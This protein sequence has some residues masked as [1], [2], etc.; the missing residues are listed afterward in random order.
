[1]Q[2]GRQEA[3]SGYSSSGAVPTHGDFSTTN[4]DALSPRPSPDPSGATTIVVTKPGE[5][6]GKGLPPSG[7]R[8][9]D[10][11]ARAKRRSDRLP[12]FSITTG[13]RTRNFLASLATRETIS[14]L[15]CVLGLTG[16]LMVYGLLQER[17]M[18]IPFGK[19]QARF[20]H[21]LFLVLCNRIVACFVALVA[22]LVTRG[23]VEPVA[24]LTSY[25]AVSV[26][27]VI[28]S[29][30]QYEALKYVSFP[31]QVLAKCVKMIPVML[32]QTII[33]REVYSVKE[34]VYA[35]VIVGGCATFLLEGNVASSVGLSKTSAVE[36]LYI[37][38]GALLLVYLA[39]DGFTSTWQDRLFS[40]YDMD[41]WN[42]VLY[43]T[44]CSIVL[45]TTGLLGTGKLWPAV[46]FMR[47]NPEAWTWVLAISLAS[48]TV[49]FFV[50]HTIKSYGAL[51]FATIMTT[52]QW[53]SI[54]LS[55]LVFGHPL[56][57]GQ[58]MGTVLVFGALYHKFYHKSRS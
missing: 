54:L 37:Y 9:S 23:S 11:S 14:A 45:S 34:Y 57:R 31:V 6:G 3:W 16:S 30:C 38:G 44:A 50:S 58:W 42:Q 21:S 18:T 33:N 35:A 25:G 36:I 47:R 12:L 5:L 55:C 19:K 32:W 53:F 29:T 7:R 39:V 22:T 28:S 2:E 27:N 17:I 26:A 1:M 40:G 4:G 43:T 24:P 51:V 13:S 20:N 15:L 41:L 10:A 56:T 52:R 8:I 48:A 49:Q 46:N